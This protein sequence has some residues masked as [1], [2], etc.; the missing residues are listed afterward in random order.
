MPTNTAD[1][2]ALP[3]DDLRRM[4]HGGNVRAMEELARRL[5]SGIG[6]PQDAQSGA[7]WLLRAAEAGSPGAAFNVG[8]MYERGFVVERDSPRAVEWYQKAADGNVAVAK[9]NLALLLREG[10]GAPRDGKKAIELLRSAARQGMSASMFS[11]GD[12]YERG[13]AAPKDAPKALAWFAVTVEFER[14]THQGSETP[15]SKTAQ[16]RLETLQRVLTPAERERAEILGQGEY[17]KILATLNPPKN[18][19]LPPTQR[20][21]F[22]GLPVSPSGPAAPPQAPPPPPVDEAASWP[23]TPID[24]VRAVQQSLIDL[25]HLKGKADGIV[26]PATRAAIR[27]FE[28]SAALR[29]AGE[30]SRD[31]YVALLKALARRDTVTHSPLPPPPRVEAPPPDPPKP[32]EPPRPIELG[33]TDSPPPPTSADIARAMPRTEPPKPDPDAW[34]AK[35]PDQ[36]REIQVLLGDLRL[37]SGAPDGEIGPITLAAIRDYQRIAGLKQT[38][39]PSKDLFESLKEMRDLMKPKPAAKPN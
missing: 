31:I 6:V 8:V 12:I 2:M 36:I 18:D 23:T 21:P 10:K 5:V 19:S 4:A 13:D 14:Q 9:H 7:G 37:M 34:P 25:H 11:L 29:E 16:Q 15:L 24:Q 26:G 35:A 28:K 1:W 38:G 27:E 20:G 33:E 22:S 3:I 32:P 30:V 17:R 39:E